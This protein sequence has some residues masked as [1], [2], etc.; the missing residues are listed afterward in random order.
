MGEREREKKVRKGEGASWGR[1]GGERIW[2]DM[3]KVKFLANLERDKT[4]WNKC[5]YLSIEVN[6]FLS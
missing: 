1:G 6:F 3:R 5:S 4:K 2:K